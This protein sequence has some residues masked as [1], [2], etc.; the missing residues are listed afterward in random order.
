M[1]RQQPVQWCG[2]GQFDS[3]S[4]HVLHHV[5]FQDDLQPDLVVISAARYAGERRCRP[6]AARD[7]TLRPPSG[8]SQRSPEGGGAGSV[9]SVGAA[10][11]VSPADC[12]RFV[13][14]RRRPLVVPLSVDGQTLGTL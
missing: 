9:P 4:C 12:A 5:F 8:E 2:L 11:G 7:L 1:N 14:R 10:D 6:S 3:Q 13:R